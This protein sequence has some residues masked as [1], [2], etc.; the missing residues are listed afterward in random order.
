MASNAAQQAEIH[1]ERDMLCAREPPGLRSAD[2]VPWRGW[3]S[4]GSSRLQ[5]AGA[6]LHAVEHVPFLNSHACRLGWVDLYT[7]ATFSK[8]R[9]HL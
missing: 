4:Q 2:R 9:M 1:L 3:H 7:L 5:R 8:L 6:G